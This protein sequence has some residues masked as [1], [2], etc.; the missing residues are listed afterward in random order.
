MLLWFNGWTGS[1]G[2]WLR[3]LGCQFPS[4]FG[5]SQSG[6]EP[7]LRS[8]RSCGVPRCY[9]ALATVTLPAQRPRVLAWRGNEGAQ[10][11]P[12]AAGTS[13]YSWPQLPLP[14]QLSP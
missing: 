11:A 2:C 7:T 5:D 13:G 3:S 8:Q 9:P 4:Q 14:L 6:K 1:S 12:G 10:R